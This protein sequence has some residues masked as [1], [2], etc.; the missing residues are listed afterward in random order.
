M[1]ID[2]RTGWVVLALGT[3][4][5]AAAWA[6]AATS[7]QSSCSP[8][9]TACRLT[10]IEASLA[11]IE[12]ALASGDSGGSLSSYAISVAS[13]EFCGGSASSCQSQAR[14]VC[15]S[16][17]FERGAPAET[18]LDGSLRYLTRA[19]CLSA[20]PSPVP[21][22]I[23]ADVFCGGSD[24]SCQREASSAC[25]VAGFSRGAPAE[26]RLDGSLRYLTRATCLD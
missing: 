15:R 20:A 2:R 7:R 1:R 22:T 5:A 14:A 11:R 6:G 19:I 4:L 9:D 13:D 23:A 21:L 10:Q 3:A 24:A 25:Q 17:E 26:T 18:R 12:R 8:D 16:A